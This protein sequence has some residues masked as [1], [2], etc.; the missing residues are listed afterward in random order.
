MMSCW[1][2]VVTVATPIDTPP[3]AE[4]FAFPRHGRDLS[5]YVREW[6]GADSLNYGASREFEAA[7]AL[8]HGLRLNQISRC[9]GLLAPATCSTKSPTH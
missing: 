5:L 6:V 7:R 1:K 2:V 8:C 9:R 3:T 4:C